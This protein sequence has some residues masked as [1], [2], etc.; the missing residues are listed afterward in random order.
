MLSRDTLTAKILEILPMV[1][2]LRHA[3][4]QIPEIAGKEE[5][6][7]ELLKERAKALDPIFW[8]P[9]LG[10][11]LIFELPGR[12]P[13][14]VIGL[15]A[16]M[17]ALPIRERADLP[18]T[19]LHEGLMHACGHDGHMSILL[20]TA[21]IAKSFQQYLPSTVRFIFQPGE[22]VLCLGADLVEK[23]A[24]DGLDSVF[25]LHNWPGLPTGSVSSK[26]GTFF[27][28]ANDFK[29]TFNGVGAHGA[30][31]EKGSN[32]L[33]PAA[34]AILR[35]KGVHDR[36]S[37]ENG[38][39]VTVCSLQGGR[40]SNVIPSKV[41]MTGTVRYTDLETGLQIEQAMEEEL[42]TTAAMYSC[43][44]EIA[45]DKGNYLPVINDAEHVEKVA[46]AVKKVLGEGAYIPAE[47]HTMGA[48]DFAF[49][50]QKTPG[51][52]F[53]LGAGTSHAP[54]HSEGF[55]FNDDTLMNGIEVFS[56]LIFGDQLQ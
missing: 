5:K 45:F 34:D 40:N 30:A 27:A 7:R 19:S 23:G 42:S 39:V 54:I 13:G 48:E 12:D 43:S 52:M 16:D 31:P 25:A 24:C 55:D 21:L 44:H 8:Q 32:P 56:A 18:Y 26:P 46:S 15:R 28:A 1:R 22:E 29:A 3:L 50:L 11:D 9:K 2:D 14:K 47:T 36:F 35:L 38:A 49:Y 20:G 4:H 41:T 6:T 53:W 33:I 17:D 51:A 10:T 37:R